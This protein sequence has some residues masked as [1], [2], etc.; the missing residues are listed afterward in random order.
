[1]RI[2]S[3]YSGKKFKQKSKV[4]R[5]SG[6]Q[7]TTLISDDKQD[8]VTY[9]ESGGKLFYVGVTEPCVKL[10]GKTANTVVKQRYKMK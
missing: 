9:V 4:P 7:K 3:K 6:G 10:A 8:T 1:M 2:D 5:K